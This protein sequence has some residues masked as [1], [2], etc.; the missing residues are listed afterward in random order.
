M[1]NILELTLC[2]EKFT[3]VLLLLSQLHF[4]SDIQLPCRNSA[5]MIMP[6][7]KIIANARVQVFRPNGRVA[8]TRMKTRKPAEEPDEDDEWVVLNPPR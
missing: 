5:I 8:P 7:L 4:P 1:W 3:Q 2:C 6:I